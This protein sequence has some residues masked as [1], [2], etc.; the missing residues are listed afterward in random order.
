MSKRISLL[1]ATYSNSGVPRNRLS[2]AAGFAS[3]GYQVDL[4]LIGGVLPEFE[5]QA[6]PEKVQVIELGKARVAAA[7]PSLVGYLRRA[8]PLAVVAAEEHLNVVAIVA[9]LLSGVSSAISVSFHVPPERE[10]ANP[11][12]R[13]GR[14]NSVLGRWL[15]PRAT[16]IVAVSTGMADALAKTARLPRDS[17]RVIH[18]PVVRDALFEMALETPWPTISH[19]SEFVLSVGRLSPNKGYADLI[20]A[21]ALIHSETNLNLVILG[22]GVAR[23]ELEAKVSA[24][25]LEDRIFLPGA[26]DNPFAWMARAKLFVLASYFEGLSNVLVEAMACGCPVVSTD[27]PTGPR[28]ILRDGRYGPLVPLRDPRALAEAMRQTLD[29]PPDVELLK[30]RA[31]D[32]HVGL[33]VEQYVEA[34]G[35]ET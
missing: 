22:E 30:R 25:G 19:G 28:E 14:W 24:L 3:R 34:L 35:L 11:L 33:I 7:L 32:F 29:N 13:K 9:V 18:N 31:M 15:F 5:R 21:F 20:D 4:V 26:V 6:L 23:S 2:L 17:I 8:R 12:W 10:A 16:A 27:C 1:L